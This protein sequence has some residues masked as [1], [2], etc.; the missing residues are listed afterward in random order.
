VT[1]AR[2]IQTPI[3][4]EDADVVRKESGCGCPGEPVLVESNWTSSCCEEYPDCSIKI[5]QDAGEVSW[6]LYG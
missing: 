2:P 4:Q 3:G 6:G 1:L 5:D